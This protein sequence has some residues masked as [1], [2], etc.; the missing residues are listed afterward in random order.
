M[1]ATKV[2]GVY[3]ADPEKVK[4]A[5]KYTKLSYDEAIKKNLKVMDQTAFSLCR[6]S[7]MKIVVFNMHKKDA[8][9][10]AAMGKKIGTLVS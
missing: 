8:I 3:T 2:D 1:K 6:E 5:K 7:K 9:L 10:N 4:K